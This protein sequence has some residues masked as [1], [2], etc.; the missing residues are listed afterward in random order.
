VGSDDGRV[1]AVLNN[2]QAWQDLDKYTK[3]KLLEP[4]AA[5]GFDFGKPLSEKAIADI[6][7]S[8]SAVEQLQELKLRIKGNE[9]YLGPIS[10]LQRLN[11]YSPAVQLQ[12]AVDLA[13][14]KIG[15]ALEGGVLRKEDEEKYKKILANLSDTPATAYSKLDDLVV[16]IERDIKNYQLGLRANGRRVGGTHP[17]PANVRVTG[18]GLPGVG[19]MYNGEKVLKVTKVSK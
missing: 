15:K 14:Q 8:Q 13:R 3:A 10:G 16:S 1:Q 17:D 7:Q 9:Q 4:L 5:A 6:T 11:P 2:P 12:A 18:G 19:G